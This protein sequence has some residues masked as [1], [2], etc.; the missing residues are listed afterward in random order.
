MN[1][2]AGGV[3][4][5]RCRARVLV[6]RPGRDQVPVVAHQPRVRVHG[7]V[8]PLRFTNRLR[9]L[10]EG[11][12]T[13]SQAL[14]P[15]SVLTKKQSGPRADSR[16]SLSQA[17]LSPL[18]ATTCVWLILCLGQTLYFTLFRIPEV[19]DLQ[20]RCHT[21]GLHREREVS[22]SPHPDELGT[23]RERRNRATCRLLPVGLSD[24]RNGLD[25]LAC[26]GSLS[27]RSSYPNRK[28]RADPRD[29]DSPRLW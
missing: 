3:A 19:L 29:R 22:V 10:H 18:P 2:Y 11:S 23:R 5:T 24:G 17:A 28:L 21:V 12:P 20:Y 8:P 27:G 16:E 7:R 14:P 6:E 13:H 25:E 1:R 26:I 15:S 9:V 4:A